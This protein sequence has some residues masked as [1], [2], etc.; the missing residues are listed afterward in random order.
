MKELLLNSPLLAYYDLNKPVGLAVSASSYGL[1]AVFSHVFDDG[2][3]K[4]IVYPF[5]GLSATELNYSII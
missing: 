3:E 2:E 5:Y 1:G 4:P